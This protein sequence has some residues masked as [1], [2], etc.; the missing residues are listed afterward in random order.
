MNIII[1]TINFRESTELK[2]FIY[3]KLDKLTILDPEIIRMEITL[4]EGAKNN[5]SN[6]WCSL[7]ISHPGENQFVKKRAGT[8][9]E[10]IILASETMEKIL[11]RN[12][13]K[14]IR[15]RKSSLKILKQM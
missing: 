8:Y 5:P 7:Y 12:K 2:D 15:D 3:D 13:S 11:R 4:K 10:S 9:E 1:Q 14:K 6:K